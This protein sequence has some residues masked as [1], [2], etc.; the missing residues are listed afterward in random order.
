M[1]LVVWSTGRENVQGPWGAAERIHGTSNLEKASGRL[2]KDLQRQ[3]IVWVEGEFRPDEIELMANDNG[4]R[5]A[6]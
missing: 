6:G 5:L 3:W 1:P 4:I 2:L